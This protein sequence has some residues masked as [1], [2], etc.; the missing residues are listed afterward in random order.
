MR[1]L[2]GLYADKMNQNTDITR[3]LKNRFTK[4]VLLNILRAS[5][6]VDLMG[7]EDGLTVCFR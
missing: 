4:H 3:Y 6:M 7:I 2:C 1:T 5:R